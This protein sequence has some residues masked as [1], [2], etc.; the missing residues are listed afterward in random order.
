MRVRVETIP[1]HGA[2][3]SKTFFL[4]GTLHHFIHSI[5]A[6]TKMASTEERGEKRSMNHIESDS[7]KKQHLSQARPVLGHNAIAVSNSARQ[8]HY[9]DFYDS[10]AHVARQ[11]SMQ[12]MYALRVQN[13]RLTE[14]VRGLM[15][16]LEEQNQLR[17][18]AVRG[19]K[20]AIY[21]IQEENRKLRK[22]NEVMHDLKRDFAILEEEIKQ[23]EAKNSLLQKKVDGMATILRGD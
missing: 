18:R 10:L 4:V 1:P 8:M 12:E 23:L 22:D 13:G 7:K 2:H 3:K 16:K 17:R 15:S 20:S 14:E 11:R 21:K 9:F 19:A 6:K 5:E